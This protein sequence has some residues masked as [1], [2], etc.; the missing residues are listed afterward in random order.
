MFSEMYNASYQ[1]LILNLAGRVTK[2]AVLPNGYEK[3]RIGIYA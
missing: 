3:M 1:E 2:S